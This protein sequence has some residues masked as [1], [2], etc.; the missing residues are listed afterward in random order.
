VVRDRQRWNLAVLVWDSALGRQAV[1]LLPN[2]LD[3]LHDAGM[4]AYKNGMPLLLSL[5]AY[6]ALLLIG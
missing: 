6:F 5:V 1:R 4:A 3:A 2:R